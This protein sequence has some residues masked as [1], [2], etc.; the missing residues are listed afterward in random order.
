MV[1][2]LPAGLLFGRARAQGPEQEL[3]RERPSPQALDDYGFRGK[4]AAPGVFEVALRRLGEPALLTA[5]AE[6]PIPTFRLLELRR[7]PRCARIV[8]D[9]GDGSAKAVLKHG[10][11]SVSIR[12]FD[13]HHGVR[14]R[15]LV[16]DRERFWDAA[17]EPP[18]WE[19]IAADSAGEI[20]VTADG[21]S[22]LLE[23]RVGPKRHA[24]V[25]RSPDD[26]ELLGQVARKVFG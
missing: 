13:A 25:R 10:Q 17:A 14:L 19:K 7:H 6:V 1:T 15:A 21:W 26:D 3:G 8:F 16:D 23:A 5:D 18:D 4:L 2:A 20:L 24:I 12:S 22:A 9:G 11:P